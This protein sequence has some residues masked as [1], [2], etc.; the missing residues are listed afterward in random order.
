MKHSPAGL[1]LVCLWM[2]MAGGCVDWRFEA[3]QVDIVLARGNAHVVAARARENVWPRVSHRQ[4]G[5][6]A[7]AY[8]SALIPGDELLRSLDIRHHATAP[9][10]DAAVMTGYHFTDWLIEAVT[11]SI[12]KSHRVR[13]YDD[14][15]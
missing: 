3:P 2:A 8:G 13:V 14:V 5:L 1:V 12:I 10:K 11:F 7:L 9:L 6:L 4:V 15:R